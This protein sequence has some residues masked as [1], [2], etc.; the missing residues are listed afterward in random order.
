MMKKVN[1]LIASAVLAF[2]LSGCSVGG[3]EQEPTEPPTE[4]KEPTES[5]TESRKPTEPQEPTEPGTE[6]QEETEIQPQGPTEPPTESQAVETVADA[7]KAF[8]REPLS[9]ALKR[10]ITGIS[11]PDGD[12]DAQI[13]YGELTYVH[14][15]HYDFS[16]EVREGELVCNQAVAEDMIEIFRE[17]YENQYPIEKIRLVDEYGGDDDASMEDN[18][19]S[20]FNYRTV[21]GTNRL[22]RHA[23]GLAIDVNPLYNPYVTTRNGKTVVSPEN[24]SIYADRSEEF[25]YKIDEEDLCYRLFTEHGFIWGGS[26]KNSKDYQHFQKEPEGDSE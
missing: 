17:L 1:I 21:E 4:S 20:C 6:S 14:V 7:G 11:F 10:R 8:Y 16:G 25:P 26:W 24:G 13:S 15:L 3:R 9:D 23:Y 22:S 2:A 18:N 12:E 19:T 5:Q